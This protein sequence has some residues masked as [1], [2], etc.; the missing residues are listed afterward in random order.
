[1]GLLNKISTQFTGLIHF[2]NESVS[3]NFKLL[4]FYLYF[5]VFSSLI[6]GEKI[7]SQKFQ[8]LQSVQ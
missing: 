7:F 4:F 1:M 3:T 5:A 2:L 6:H 8:I